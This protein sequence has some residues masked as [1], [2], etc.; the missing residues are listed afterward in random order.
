MIAASF[1]CGLLPVGAACAATDFEA[2]T[3]EFVYS[4]LALSPVAA[5]A[6]GYHRHDGVLLDEDLDDFSPSGI[7]RAL[8]F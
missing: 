6:Q 7:E 4:S 1:L 5:T 2:L 3:G 8:R